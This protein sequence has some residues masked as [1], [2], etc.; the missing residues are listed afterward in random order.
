VTAALNAA[1]ER[2]LDERSSSSNNKLPQGRMDTLLID[3]C[4]EDPLIECG[5]AIKLDKPIW[6]MDEQLLRVRSCRKRMQKE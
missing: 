1:V 5:V 4:I 3:L 6:N 2:I